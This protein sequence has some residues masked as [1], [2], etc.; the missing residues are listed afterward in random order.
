MNSQF[1]RGLSKI[2]RTIEV[3]RIRRVWRSLQAA[4]TWS[5]SSADSDGVARRKIGSADADQPLRLQKV[6]SPQYVRVHWTHFPVVAKGRLLT[7]TSQ[8]SI[9]SA[10]IYA[11]GRRRVISFRSIEERGFVEFI[12]TI[13][14]IN[15]S[16]GS[17]P[18]AEPNVP[19][20]LSRRSDV[21]MKEVFSK[22]TIDTDAWLDVLV[23]VGC[24]GV[25][26]SWGGGWSVSGALGYKLWRMARP[27]L[28]HQTA[29][30]WYVTMVLDGLSDMVPNWSQ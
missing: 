29:V 20:F 1:G 16:S 19:R 11:W 12:I 5:A 27:Y 4:N 18:G 21:F 24:G 2:S 6:Y 15:W 8:V 7:S 13:S 28:S 26:I 9:C 17:A 3:S 25:C 23:G 14:P 22:K 30:W 10:I